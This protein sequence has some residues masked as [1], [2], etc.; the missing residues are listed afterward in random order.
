[1][2]FLNI[3]KTI[4]S[5]LFISISAH[6]FG[7]K[8]FMPESV[9]Y[10]KLPNGFSYYLLPDDGE[11]GKITVHL[12]SS[13]GSLVEAP[14]ERGVGHFIEHMVFKGS[15]NFP[16]EGTMKELDKMGLRIGRDYNASVSNTLTEYHINLP[17]DNWDYLQQTLLLMKD[18]VSD[19]EM[20]EESFK[21]EQKVV[22]EE[23]RKRNSSVSPY[24]IGTPLEGHDGLGTEEQINSITSEEVKTFY[25]KYYTPDNVALVIQGKVNEKKVIRFIESTFGQIPAKKNTLENKYIDL[26]K[27]TVIDS[28]Y[29][30]S[31]KSN[32]PSLVLAFKAPSV[33]ITSYESFKINYI[34]YLFSMILENRLM[35][36]SDDDLNETNV[37]ISEIL[38]G[39]MMYNIRMQGKNQISYSKMLDIFVKVI[40]EARKNGFSQE[41]IDYFLDRLIKKNEAEGSDEI[42]RFAAAQKHFL[43]GDTPL[44]K[45]D[46]RAYFKELQETITPEDFKSV[47]QNFTDYHKTI[48]YDRNSVSFTS[49]FQGS[50]ILSKLGN[51]INEVGDFPKYVFSEPKGGFMIRVAKNLSDI[52][53]PQN[54]PLAVY[55]KKNLGEGLY[56]LEFKNGMSVLVNNAPTVKA[57]IKLISKHGLSTLPENDTLIFKQ[58]LA[59]FNKT[60]VVMMKSKLQIC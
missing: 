53:V 46:R 15:K 34:D 28:T 7:Q 56:L 18:W 29:V 49:D 32:V 57:Q 23:I 6:S 14:N 44:L 37:M 31:F 2:F 54:N 22:I 47:L 41:E 30:S 42:I 4:I 1:M 11:R 19:L 13:V 59:L 10:K 35:T 5:L 52:E 16:G 50:Y 43:T 17:Q 20:E 40:A 26:T 38:P 36:F 45:M 21:V 51:S 27:K 39:S 55:R 25:H 48:L 9:I 3:K 60:L 33:A 12:L 8:F 24:L 58:T